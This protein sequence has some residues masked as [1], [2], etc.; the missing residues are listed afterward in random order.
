[1][2]LISFSWEGMISLYNNSSII[3]HPNKPYNN[4]TIKPYSNQA[5][6]Q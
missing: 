4:K 5:I 2:A 6:W 3:Q 1:M